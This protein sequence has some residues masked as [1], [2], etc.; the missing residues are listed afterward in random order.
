MKH[1]INALALGALL[2]TT[3]SGLAV[4]AQ[5]IRAIPGCPPGWVT[6]T[7][8]VNPQLKCLPGN[9][10]AQPQN[11]EPFQATQKVQLINKQQLQGPSQG[12]SPGFKQAV[13]P[14]NPQLGCLPTN[15]QAAPNRP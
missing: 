9:I 6:A 4:K 8:P 7:P 2:V 10:L 3:G 5:P 11:P 13:H 14:L 12:C 1:F 15:L